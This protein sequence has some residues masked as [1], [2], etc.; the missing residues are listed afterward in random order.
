MIA[1]R[2]RD[3][4]AVDW[5]PRVDEKLAGCAIQAFRPNGDQVHRRIVSV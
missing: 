1:V 2:V 3:H 5:P 4:C